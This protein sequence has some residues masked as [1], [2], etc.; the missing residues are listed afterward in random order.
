MNKNLQTT[1]FHLSWD[2]QFV[3]LETNI[4]KAKVEG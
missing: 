3:W 4:N 1:L 2:R